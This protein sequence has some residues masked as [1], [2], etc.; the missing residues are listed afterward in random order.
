MSKVFLGGT[1]NNSTWR[2]RI[3]PFLNVD[4][5]NP[6]VVDWT[7][8]CIQNEINE[9]NCHCDIHLYVITQRMTGVYSIAEVINS[10]HTKD[11]S[12]IFYVVKKGFDN[13][14]IK[15]LNAVGDMVDSLGGLYLSCD[16][17]CDKEAKELAEMLENIVGD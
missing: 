5:F 7:P 12:V 3:M 16:E 10:C 2:D 1:C 17:F 13:T 11:K 15:S 9:K 6:V 14:Q 4:Y 8:E